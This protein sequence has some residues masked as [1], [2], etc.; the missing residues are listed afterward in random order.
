M[1]NMDPNTVCLGNSPFVQNRDGVHAGEPAMLTGSIAVQSK[2]ISPSTSIAILTISP[3]AEDK[4][5][6]NALPGRPA[7]DGCPKYM[8]SALHCSQDPVIGVEGEPNSKSWLSAY[9]RTERS[10]GQQAVRSELALRAH[11]L[12]LQ[13]A[14]TL[15]IRLVQLV[16]VRVQR[17]YD[18]QHLQPMQAHRQV[19]ES[20]FDT[21]FRH[22]FKLCWPAISGQKRFC[23]PSHRPTLKRLSGLL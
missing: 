16:R 7:G 17:P 21:K 9:S 8:Q 3:K 18:A 23:L 12:A 20:P 13:L 14:L 2:W 5:T 10:P 22:I 6:P 19:S 1:S 15:Q 4:G 11:A